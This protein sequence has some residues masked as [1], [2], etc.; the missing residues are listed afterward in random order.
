MSDVE[1][2]D[3]EPSISAPAT[4]DA[5]PAGAAPVSRDELHRQQRQLRAGG[6]AL[7]RRDV[8]RVTGPDAESF[9]QGQLSADITVVANE[10]ATWSLLLGPGGKMG[11][12]LR[13]SRLENETFIVDV[14][15][16]FG[17]AVVARLERFKLRTKAEITVDD[18]DDWV[19]MAVRGPVQV[20]LDHTAGST[21]LTLP[22]PWPGLIGWDVLAPASAHVRI[23]TPIVGPEAL[24]AVRVECG[25]PAIGAEIV[26]DVIA[27]EIGQWMIDASVS[28]TK[29]CYTGQELV[30]RIDSRGG[31]VPRRLRAV[32]TESM[33]AVG[34]EVMAAD[35]VVGVLTSVAD[36]AVVG[37]MGLALVARAVEPSAV[38]A[39]RSAGRMV[40]AQVRQLPVVDDLAGAGDPVDVPVSLGS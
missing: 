17:A 28:F 18:P 19:A 30:A 37:P 3:S 6:A 10:E 16:G 12:W 38:V 7:L 27:A 21:V 13:V 23:D 20:E 39:V 22:A 29:G 9:L 25:V 34:D 33:C 14:D 1:T 24:D 32:V 31:N 15:R 36:S 5:N 4:H 35:K 8:V 40:A 2:P 11:L 26:D